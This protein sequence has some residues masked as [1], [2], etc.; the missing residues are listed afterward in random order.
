MSQALST[1][2]VEQFD[3]EVKQAY[4][5]MKTLRECVTLRNN[6]TGDKY[7]FRL[8][9]KG[10]ATVRTGSSAD[11]V[12]MGVG[13]SL[14]QA[15]LVDYEAPE[16][17]DVYD[18][19][20]VNF[21]EVVHLAET[22]AG[23]MGRRDDQSIIDAAI[24]G[25][26]TT[27]ADGGTNLTVAKLRAAVKG[28]NAVE[29][30]AGDRYC[31]IDQEGLDALLGTTEVTSSDY[32]N[33]KSLVH[34]EVDTFLGLKFKVIGNRAEG[35]LPEAANVISGI[36]FH[37]AA[38]GHAVGIDMKTTVDYVAHKASWLSMGLWKAGS[39]AIDP[40]GIIKVNYDKT[41]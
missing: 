3:S 12:P 16:Y 9:G 33:V 29:A 24:A 7:D 31:I 23:A 20:T 19:A 30:P 41:A 5:G 2:A 32:N 13:H 38:L 4:Q 26:G 6:V 11:V 40:E 37:K 36:V 1:V 17:T 25:A 21:D 8:M 10:A 39:K 28:L 27:V 34:G 35:G 14:K 18:A 15:V 22:I